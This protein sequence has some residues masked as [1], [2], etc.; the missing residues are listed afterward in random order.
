MQRFYIGHVYL[1]SCR[2]LVPGLA[3][4]SQDLGNFLLNILPIPLACTPFFDAHDLQ[5]WS[6]DV[7]AALVH[8]P[9]S[10]FE[11]FV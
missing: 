10:T 6:F 2:L 7:L 3:S 11:S 4:L 1:M 9:F 8:I 5:V